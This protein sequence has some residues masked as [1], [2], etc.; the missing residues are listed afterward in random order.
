MRRCK[1]KYNKL[2]QEKNTS[3]EIRARNIVSLVKDK[4]D[5]EA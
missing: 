1:R 2:E 4:K 3:D 5:L